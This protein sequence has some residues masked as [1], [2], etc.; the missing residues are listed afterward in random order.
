MDKLVSSVQA[1][2]KFLRLLRAVRSGNSFLVTARAALLQRLGR[3]PA[4]AA[5]TWSRDELY[6]RASGSP[7]IYD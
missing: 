3:Q 5:G 4:A 7:G 2:R 6:D 1:S